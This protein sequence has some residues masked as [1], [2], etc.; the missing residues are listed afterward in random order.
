[1]CHLNLTLPLLADFLKYVEERQ[2][3]NICSYISNRE[4]VQFGLFVSV[5]TKSQ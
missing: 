4:F 5:F 3:R 2:M 1:M